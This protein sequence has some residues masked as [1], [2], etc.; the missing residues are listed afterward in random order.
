MKLA[1]QI[2]VYFHDCCIIVEL[3]AVVRGTEDG[4]KLPAGEKLVP[5]LDDLMSPANQVDVMLFAEALYDILAKNI[6][7]TSIVWRPPV[8][9]VWIS[10]Q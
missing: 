9:L 4:D 2:F 5:V 7:Y 10:P 1:T 3:T 6:G 8:D